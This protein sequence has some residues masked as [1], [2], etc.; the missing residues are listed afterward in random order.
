M[1]NGVRSDGTLLLCSKHVDVKHVLLLLVGFLTC[2]C[3]VD[4]GPCLVAS[5]VVLLSETWN[6]LM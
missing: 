6:L 4:I 1:K 2:K 3:W 5:A